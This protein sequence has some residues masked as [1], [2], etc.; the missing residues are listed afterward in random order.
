MDYNRGL[1]RDTGKEHG[2]YMK[3]PVASKIDV[4]GPQQKIGILVRESGNP[5]SY[6]HKVYFL[7]CWSPNMRTR[8]APELFAKRRYDET[9]AISGHSL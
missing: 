4:W 2:N 1:H 6:S 3:L 8:Q 5:C 7:H 9:V